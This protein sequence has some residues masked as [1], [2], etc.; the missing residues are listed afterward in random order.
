[1]LPLWYDSAE[2]HLDPGSLRQSGCSFTSGQ[3]IS[4]QK[5]CDLIVTM[6]ETGCWSFVP[7][8][9][10]LCCYFQNVLCYAS[11]TTTAFSATCSHRLHCE[12]GQKCSIKGLRTKTLAQL[13]QPFGSLEELVSVIANKT[14]T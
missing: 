8:K 5:L 1:M 12:R 6:T 2:G 11:K 13:I 7:L 10:S 14:G 3:C 4:T 9:R